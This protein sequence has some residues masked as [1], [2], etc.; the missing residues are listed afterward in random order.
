M[1]FRTKDMFIRKNLLH[2]LVWNKSLMQLAVFFSLLRD[3]ILHEKSFNATGDS[4]QIQAGQNWDLD[5]TE[6]CACLN[7]PILT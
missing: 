7:I 1:G 5:L 6:M 2:F 4:S 3:E